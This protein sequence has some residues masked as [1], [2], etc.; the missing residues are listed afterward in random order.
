MRAYCEENY[1]ENAPTVAGVTRGDVIVALE[2]IY[3]AKAGQELPPFI[4]EMF[5]PR[6]PEIRD[7]V[8]HI[9]CIGDSITWGAGVMIPNMEFESTY[10]VFLEKQ[11]GEEYQVLNYGMGGRTLLKDGDDPYVEENFY[12]IS[13]ESGADIFVIMLGTNDSKPYNWNA[14]SYRTELE[15]FVR[16]YMELPNA[17]QIYLM[18]P[19]KAFVVD[20]A[21]KVDYD[22]QDDVI[23][24][25]IV[26]IVKE[27]AKLLGVNLIDMYAE[28]ENHPEWFPDGVHPDAD[29]NVE[30]AKIVA[31]HLKLS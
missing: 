10:P 14:E 3:S 30:F 17:P 2:T 26:P 18:T 7:G 12:E 4:A 25:E 6:I 29:G 22:I 27:V 31:R 24:N 23:C 1:I 11:L 8:T 15:A 19:P 28:T 20:G 21:E 9:A 13:H 16:S 5:N